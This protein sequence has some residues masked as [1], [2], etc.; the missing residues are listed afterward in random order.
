MAQ[1]NELIDKAE[2]VADQVL[3]FMLLFTQFVSKL[4]KINC[5]TCLYIRL[6]YVMKL[7]SVT[8]PCVICYDVDFV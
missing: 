5:T 4:K 6:S 8:D 3:Y 2:D 7:T 1:R